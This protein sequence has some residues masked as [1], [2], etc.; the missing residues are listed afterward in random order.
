MGELFSYWALYLF[1]FF[2]GLL[3]SLLVL[4]VGRIQ[5]L[6]NIARPTIAISITVILVVILVRFISPIG[7][8][9]GWGLYAI[10][11]AITGALL[12]F[13]WFRDK[14]RLSLTPVLTLQLIL[15]TIAIDVLI[16]TMDNLGYGIS[17]QHFQ[18]LHGNLDSM[19]YALRDFDQE[20]NTTILYLIIGTI[21]QLIPFLL[22]PFIKYVKAKSRA[23]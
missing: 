5:K 7:D 10:P 22:L 18:L 19:D 13:G 15:G 6:K 8:I 4:L 2:G 11:P 17:Y 9:Y 3:V 21:L 16:N 14:Y 1:P 20:I 12:P 23:A